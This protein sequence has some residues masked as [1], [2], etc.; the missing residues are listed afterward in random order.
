MTKISQSPST[1]NKIL[2]AL[3]RTLSSAKK[4]LVVLHDNPDPDALASGMALKALCEQHFDLQVTVTYGGLINRA[5]NKAMVQELEI[6][7]VPFDSIDV[8]SFDRIAT[9]DTQPGRGNN[10]LPKKA[11]CHVVF[12]HHASS[13]SGKSDLIVY[14]RKI[15]ATV[16]LLGELLLE[17]GLE[18]KP[19]LATAVV[20]AIRTETQELRRE[21]TKRDISVYLKLYPLCSLKKLGLIAQPTLPH[22]YF[23]MLLIALQKAQIFR[24]ILY[25]PIGE[26]DSPEIV[27]EMADFFLRRERVTWVLVTGLYESSMYL[28]LR[29]TH[30]KGQAFRVM[31]KVIDDR[32]NAGGHETFAGGRIDFDSFSEFKHIDEKLA[33]RYADIF[34]FKEVTWKKLLQAQ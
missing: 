22:E 33:A 9:V 24:Q 8:K 28:S 20:Y 1:I 14:N 16:T 5:E 23:E 17:S 4:L 27:A 2:N 30:M 29:T 19:Y 15:G 3:K 13:N 7:I 12:D 11:H 18:I 6:E 31:Q 10:A 34:G 25:V 21:A 26:V 32:V